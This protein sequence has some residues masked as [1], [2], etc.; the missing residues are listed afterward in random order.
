MTDED[1]IARLRS[2][3]GDDVQHMY[4]H[5]ALFRISADRIEQLAKE[6]HTSRMASVI[7]DNTVAEAEAKLAKAMK[8]IG[9]AVELA[10]FDSNPKLLDDMIYFKTEFELDKEV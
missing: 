7:M 2:Q 4:D 3:I 9:L 8:F 10:R 1:L 6:L 5:E